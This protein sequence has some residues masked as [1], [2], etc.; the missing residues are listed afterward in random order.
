MIKRLIL[1]ACLALSCT[2][3]TQVFLTSTATLPTWTVPSNWNNAANTIEVIGGGSC[4]SS[5]IGS[6]G[7]G[8]GAYTKIVNLT[9]TPGA[10]ITY[11]VGKGVTTGCG[12][13]AGGDTWFNGSTLSASSVG[14]KG[15]SGTSSGTGGPGGQASACVGISATCFSGGSGGNSTGG[16]AASAEC[17]RCLCAAPQ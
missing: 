11:Q 8:G 4:P 7:A 2:A 17:N 16:F 1:L 15:G 13:P 3:Q 5:N 12:S 6:G 10:S 9:L 14:A